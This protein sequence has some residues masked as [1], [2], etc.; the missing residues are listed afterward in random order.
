MNQEMTP[1]PLIE[2]EMINGIREGEQWY[3][4]ASSTVLEVISG[5]SKIGGIAYDDVIAAARQ[6][7]NE[8]YPEHNHQWGLFDDILNQFSID[9]LIESGHSNRLYLRGE[10]PDG[11]KSL[12]SRVALKNI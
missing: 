12:L 9:G 1:T 11:A 3:A 4:L 6:K 8:D 5:A 7:L 10:R 2:S